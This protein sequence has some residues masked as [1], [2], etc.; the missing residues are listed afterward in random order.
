MVYTAVNTR[1]QLFPRP[2]QAD[3]AD[4]VGRRVF[5][6]QDGDGNPADQCHLESANDPARVAQVER[7]G[8]DRIR[9]GA[10]GDSLLGSEGR[11]TLLGGDGFGYARDEEGR[12]E[13]VPQIGRVVVEDD[14]EIGANSAVDRG[15]LGATV[16]GRG[17]KLD[18]LVML[19]HGVRLGDPDWAP[20]SRSLAAEVTGPG[21]APPAG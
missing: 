18:D 14:V 12:Y 17:S 20:H 10:D 7:R 1:I 6:L 4:G 13:A 3:L 5:L 11:D 19:A 16:V 9:G 15:A 21:G 8:A 2:V